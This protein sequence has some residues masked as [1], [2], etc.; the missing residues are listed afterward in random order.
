MRF[1]IG[2]TRTNTTKIFAF[3]TIIQIR[4]GKGATDC[5]SSTFLHKPDYS[6]RF[7]AEFYY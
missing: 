4:I 1:K 6:V 7:G 3:P 5:R 2:I